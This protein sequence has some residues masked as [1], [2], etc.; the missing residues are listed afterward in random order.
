[1]SECVIQ[2]EK[3]YLNGVCVMLPYSEQ[4]QFGENTPQNH[5]QDE[6]DQFFMEAY[7][8]MRFFLRT[9]TKHKAN[10]YTFFGDMQKHLFYI[11]D[12]LKEDFGFESNIVPNFITEWEKRIYR[13]NGVEKYRRDMQ[14]LFE[15]KQSV[16]D[17]RYQVQN[18]DGQ[19][20]WIRCCGEIQWDKDKTKPLF[21]AGRVTKQ[22][23]SFVVDPV[24]NF[25]SGKALINHISEIQDNNISCYALGF[26][27]NNVSLL[28]NMAGRTAVDRMIRQISTQL[29]DELFE[30]VMFY[31][32]PGV[33]CVA[34]VEGKSELDR[35]KLI[36]HIKGVIEGHYLKNGFSVPNPCSFAYMKL[37][38]KNVKASELMERMVSLIKMA[39][40]NQHVAYI[41]DSKENKDKI[42]EYSKM[43]MAI[44]QDVQN[45]M[46]HFRPV[47]QPVVSVES[48][49]IMAGETLMRWQFEGK[50]VSPG[51]F[52]PVL[53][54]NNMIQT[55]G[56]WIFEQAAAF[57]SRVIPFKPH[58]YLTVN[59]SLQQ[60]YDE[61]FTDYI[62]ETLDKYQLDGSHIVIEMTESCMDR[63]PQKLLALMT[64]CRKWGIRFAL[65]DFGTGYSSLRV[66]LHYPTDIIKL[67][68]SLLLEMI[69][70]KDKMNFI[71]S[72]V[73][74]CHR[75]DK[76]VCMEGVETEVQ[77]EFVKKTYCDMIQGFYYYKPTELDDL[78]RMAKEQ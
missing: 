1:M 66:L 76:L 50:D 26:C 57:C 42:Y 59:V 17:L 34:I 70:S 71:S 9:I 19:I 77:D 2:I 33:R 20:L 72:I 51:A 61:G 36:K 41:K 45:G 48:G 31:R 29:M 39:R 32:L 44:C 27:Y 16:H 40:H 12:N 58:F 35:D 15:N 6:L 5:P 69:E 23:D 21:A 53:E 28:N 62:K 52:I 65:D 11:S 49:S 67:D 73:F 55:A 43:E 22:D 8:D 68:R 63:E 38:Q 7:H 25:P 78:F 56:R 47:V 4:G 30:N 24:T 74:A 60:L 10:S 18:K 13:A 64:S 54:K 37:P 46:E 3:G 75:F 14:R